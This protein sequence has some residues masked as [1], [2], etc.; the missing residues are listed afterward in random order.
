[1]NTESNMKRSL[2]S[3]LTELTSRAMQLFAAFSFLLLTLSHGDEASV[4]IDVKQSDEPLP[5]FVNTW[6]EV[7]AQGNSE[8][9]DYVAEIALKVLQG[10]AETVSFQLLGEGEVESVAE[11]N[12]KEGA[13]SGLQGWAI[14]QEGEKRF[15]DLSLAEKVNE[16]TLVVRAQRAVKSLPVDA[17]IWHLGPATEVSFQEVIRINT[18]KEL[19]GSQWTTSGFE[20]LGNGYRVFTRTGGKLGWRLKEREPAVELEIRDAVLVGQPA[21]DSE[22]INFVLKG[23]VERLKQGSALLPILQG[24]AALLA[25]GDSEAWKVQLGKGFWDKNPEVYYLNTKEDGVYQFEIPFVAPVSRVGEWSKVKFTVPSVAL[26]P[27]ELTGFGA[28]NFSE[29]ASIRPSLQEG[30]KSF[31]RGYAPASGEVSLAWREGVEEE[32]GALFFSSEGL[33]DIRV[34]AGLLRQDSYLGVR[35]LQGELEEL[36]LALEGPGEVL[37]VEGE[38]VLSWARTESGLQVRFR[39]AVDS[40]LQLLVR[41]QLVLAEFPVTAASLSLSPVGTVRHAGYLRVRNEG[42]VRLEMKG[43]EGLMQLAP[44]EFPGEQVEA[45]QLFVYR[46]PA[47]AY[48]FSVEAAQISPEVSVNEVVLY[49]LGDSDRAIKADVELDIRE[50]ALREWEMG[51][52]EDYSVVSVSGAKVGDYV[53]GS[54]VTE[55][56][57]LLR[58]IFAEE[59]AGRQLLNLHLEKNESVTEGEWRLPR[60]NYPSAKAV[61]GDVG[62]VGAAGF[63][64]TI[65]SVEKLAEKPLSFFPK[66]QEGLQLAF[67]VRERDWS[68]T[69]LVERLP[70]SVEADVFHL[71]SLKDGT[72]FGSVVV[73]YFITGSPVDEWKLAVPEN[74]GNVAVDGQNVRAW[75]REGNEVIVTLQQPVIGLYTLLLTCEEPVGTQGGV[76]QPGR[77]IPLGVRDERGYLQV[78][79]PVQVKPEV[80][81]TSDGLLKLDALELPAEFRLSSSAPSLAVYQYTERPFELGMKIEWYEPGE[82]VA[83]VVEFA[84]AKSRI[85][86]D[87]EVVTDATYSV[88]TRGG[89]VLRLVLPAEVRLW[90]VRV[91]DTPVTA[92]RDGEATLVPLPAGADANEA[93]EVQ[94]RYGRAA[95]SATHPVLALPAV[96]APVLK[97]EWNIKGD[98]R[99]RLVLRGK[100]RGESAPSGFDWVAEYGLVP[101]ALFLLLVSA[102]IVAARRSRLLAGLVLIGAACLLVLLLGSSWSVAPEGRSELEVS[103]PVLAAGEVI[104]AQ[105]GNFDKSQLQWDPSGG[106]AILVGLLVVAWATLRGLPRWYLFG[107]A[108]LA[109]GGALWMAGGA[110]YFYLLLSLLLLSQIV[111]LWGSEPTPPKPEEPTEPQESGGP[112]PIAT[113]SAVL[114]LSLGLL[115]GDSA[116]GETRVADLLTQTW[117]VEN[118]EVEATAEIQFGGEIGTTITL[119]QGDVVLKDFAGEGLRLEKLSEGAGYAVVI[120]SLPLPQVLE[121]PVAPVNP[122]EQ[123]DPFGGAE[124]KVAKR[125]E[126]EKSALP[127]GRQTRS[128]TFRYGMK[129]SG[130]EI[131]LPTP[132]AAVNQLQVNLAKSGWSIQSPQA[133]KVKDLTV[134]EGSSSQLILLPRAG[135]VISLAPRERDPQQEETVFFVEVENAY[136]SGP[137]LLEGRHRISVNPSQGVVRRLKILIPAG[138]AVS[139]LDEGVVADWRFS[140][141]SR[142]LIVELQEAFSSPFQF[143]V[144]TQKSLGSLPL[145]LEVQPLRVVGGARELGL[146]GLAFRGQAQAETVSV[147]GLLEVNLADFERDLLPKKAGALHRAYRYGAEDATAKLRVVPV[148]AEVRVESDEIL[149]VGAERTL[150]KAGMLVEITRAGI[151]RL[152][153]PIPE[154]FE[155]ES[156]SGEAMSHWNESGEGA[157]RTLTVHLRGQ[158][159][160][161]HA[162]SLVLAKEGLL[163]AEEN[164]VVPRVVINEAARQ[165]GQLI[166]RAEQGLRLRTLNRKNVSEVDPRTAGSRSKDEVA[167]AFRLLQKEWEL[168]LGIEKLDPWVTGQVLQEMALREGQARN[169]VIGALKIENAAVQ[170]VQVRLDGLSEEAAKTVRASGAAVSGISPVEGEPGLWVVGFKR[171]VIGEQQLR[172]EWERTGERADGIEM[173]T[174]VAFPNLRQLTYYVAL[175]A[176]AQLEVMAGELPT[177]WY[178][179]DWTAVPATLRESGAG[180]IPA[181]V[182]RGGESALPVSVTRH[183]VAEALKLRVSEGK[184]T[185]VV[186]PMGDLLTAVTLQLDVIQR[187]NLRIAFPTFTGEKAGSLPSLFNVFVNGES[188]SVV[189]DGDGYLFYVVPGTGKKAAEVKFAYAVDGDPARKISLI[190]PELSVPLENIEWRVIVPD[191]FELKESF[192]DLALEEEEG[193]KSFS[194]ESYRESIVALNSSEKRKA[195]ATIDQANS[196]LQEGQ[197]EQALQLFQNVANNYNLDDATNEDARVMLNR[198]QTDQVVAGLNSRRQ[199]LYLDN[200]VE[201]LGFNRNSQLETAAAANG[202]LQGE[203]NFRPEE[204]GQLLLGNSREENDFLR[205]IADRLVKH[206]KAT[207]PAPQAISVPVPEEGK[208]YLFRRSVRVDEGAP[209]KLEM[210]LQ[211]PGES[212]DTR[213]ALVALLALAA[214]ACLALGGR[215]TAG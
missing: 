1:M 37:A 10:E 147:V 47:A 22:A 111:Q 49:E 143:L 44:D 55:G 179:L 189:R 174:P 79:S 184:L 201:D 142:E 81:T 122:A 45:R 82:T 133:A 67:R 112:D 38:G 113:Q 128:A 66:R 72:A 202:I 87:G 183:A 125:V 4:K 138:L 19:R 114:L 196:F 78:V 80:A 134:E 200:R 60:L 208:V 180:G 121:G 149:S 191:G 203:V 29:D 162:F 169:V 28:V 213:L 92:R 193:W 205:R 130:N 194:K 215:R 76:V 211:H 90:E 115:F 188:V 14:R 152:S 141:E 165:T 104:R 53:V 206:Q 13:E 74:A 52:P 155:V 70:R 103:V 15:L 178:R 102:A 209:L 100:E 88:K 84:E 25:A 50:A 123:G 71:Y 118:G 97:T 56:R 159:E 99:R 27:V 8:S 54:E 62:I 69:L 30:I 117:Q 36:T 161:R 48:R 207:E 26:L 167:L 59:V 151:F 158:T 24:N 9:F 57:R 136:V 86:R 106:I 95:V 185:T 144:V 41:S 197:Q 64:I 33:V 186:S 170:E 204:L 187:S 199:R 173:V 51:I 190:S 132:T 171:R 32:D 166:V 18:S 43:V 17:L 181:V 214:A 96:A 120:Q 150:L 119:L 140:A 2:T 35:V 6:I 146:L 11:K 175:R 40:Q 63:R 65:G 177:G 109:A 176:G 73:N 85:S 31:W 91:G 172:I 168:T 127:K 212:T 126:P 182:L 198:V 21:T 12:L 75:R 20:F 98:E 101:T 42:A 156:F 16:L 107:G 163:S 148:A 131:L 3:S 94:V 164:W 160:G 83:Q 145:E 93:V 154:G 34:G 124:E 89:R 137:G 61:R 192:G 68:S 7:E 58:V 153:F 5:V 39:E 108:L 23:T 210:D 157:E 116:H 105:V 46:F 195:E 110:F 129:Y 77:V 135:T 139:G